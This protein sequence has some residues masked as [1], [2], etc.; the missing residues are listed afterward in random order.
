M[1][2]T[3]PIRPSPRRRPAR[4][5]R[6][7]GERPARRLGS[8][9]AERPAPTPDSEWRSSGDHH[10]MFR[11]ISTTG[12]AAAGASVTRLRRPIADDEAAIR[13]HL[14]RRGRR[15]SRRHG[16]GRRGLRTASDPV[17][18]GRERR[19]P[20]RRHTR[21]SATTA[22]HQLRKGLEAHSGPRPLNWWPG[23]LAKLHVTDP[24]HAQ[25]DVR[26]RSSSAPTA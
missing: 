15:R 16:R 17:G 13:P 19:T 10:E 8:A 5:G 23:A 4:P 2:N 14:G 18:T 3:A 21:A 12:G 25:I 22:T 6:H 7:Q 24:G 20:G 9:Q 1:P 26:A 11:K